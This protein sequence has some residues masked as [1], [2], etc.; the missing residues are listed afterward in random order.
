MGTADQYALFAN[1][2][3]PTLKRVMD[4]L[5]SVLCRHEQPSAWDMVNT[6]ER[7]VGW[8]ARWSV[9]EAVNK[10]KLASA[11]TQARRSY[12]DSLMESGDLDAALRGADAPKKEI[13][14]SID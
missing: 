3:V 8:K 10:L 2:E 7:E 5:V 4:V 9:K 12:L 13:A 1:E 14:S 11:V 6:I